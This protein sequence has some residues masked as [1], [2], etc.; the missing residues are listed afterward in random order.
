[1]Q[2]LIS[3]NPPPQRQ[4]KSHKRSLASSIPATFSHNVSIASDSS[5]G[6]DILLSPDDCD[7]WSSSFASKYAAGN[8]LPVCRRLGVISRTLQA[9]PDDDGSTLPL[10]NIRASNKRQKVVPGSKRKVYKKSIPI[11]TITQAKKHIQG[12]CLSSLEEDCTVLESRAKI[13]QNDWKKIRDNGPFQKG[14]NE[15]TGEIPGQQ[16]TC[17]QLLGW[18][19]GKEPKLQDLPDLPKFCSP[20]SNQKS[21]NK[22][23]LIPFDTESVLKALVEL[24]TPLPTLYDQPLIVTTVK[25]SPQYGNQNYHLSIGIYVSSRRQFERLC[26]SALLKIKIL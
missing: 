18:I 24:M 21:L 13:W 17:R 26:F 10:L 16:T 12:H 22:E 19:T 8:Y 1:M 7:L 11:P 25:L 14:W 6:S 5:T 2:D 3:W 15:T 23:A 4:P 20:Y 9:V